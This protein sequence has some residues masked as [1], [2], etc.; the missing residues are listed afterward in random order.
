MSV[1]FSSLQT[2]RLLA[3][4][5]SGLR[6]KEDRERERIIITDRQTEMG[7]IVCKSDNNNNN[8]NSSIHVHANQHVQPPMMINNLMF[9]KIKTKKKK[10]K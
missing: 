1:Q 10:A 2:H 8:N 9:L 3:D 4:Y 7:M 5:I 6:S